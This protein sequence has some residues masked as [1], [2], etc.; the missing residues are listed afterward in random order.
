MLL[1]ICVPCFP[2]GQIKVLSTFN[3]KIKDN[4]DC[5]QCEME[6]E[7]RL[8]WEERRRYNEECD[9]MEWCRR[10]GPP[11]PPPHFAHRPYPPMMPPYA[12]H[13]PHVSTV[14][15]YSLNSYEA[16]LDRTQNFCTYLYMYILINLYYF[17][18]FYLFISPLKSNK[19]M[20]LSNHIT[21][22][23]IIYSCV[24]IVCKLATFINFC[25][26]LS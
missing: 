8:Y 6:E 1:K 2:M 15:V 10:S 16:T 9:Y 19:Q 18:I 21:F 13:P 22:Y 11:M 17:C 20:S 25:C 7:E 3:L 4:I 24:K 14:V 23:C 12:P 5:L 26:I